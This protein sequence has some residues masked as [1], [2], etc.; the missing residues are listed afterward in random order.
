MVT[1]VKAGKLKKPFT[2]QNLRELLGKALPSPI[3]VTS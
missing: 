3:P 2:E 1:A